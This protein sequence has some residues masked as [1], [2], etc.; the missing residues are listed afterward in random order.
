MMPIDQ[1]AVTEA[2]LLEFCKEFM[3]QPYLCY[4]EH[5]LHALFYSR[6]FDA[7]GQDE[8]RYDWFDG[9]RVCLIQKEYPTHHHLGRSRRQH[10]DISVLK[11][12]LEGPGDTPAYDHFRLAAVVEFALNCGRGHLQDD[13]E[14]LTHP[15]ANVDRGFLV[16][17]YRFS[18]GEFR[19]SDRDWNAR[20][21]SRL[22]LETVEEMLKG[23]PGL[24]VLYG[25]VDQSGG[26]G[27]GLWKV[28]SDGAEPITWRLPLE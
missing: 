9:L 16:H 18:D 27:K 19:V 6:L 12:P 24:Y 5:G 10:W 17:L 20:Y 26:S 8:H 2:T 14:R 28:T 3:R 1:A 15:E 11:A 22:K 7:F 25:T 13:I 21:K 23:Y 4:T